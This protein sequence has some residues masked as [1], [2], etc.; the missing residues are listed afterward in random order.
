[1]PRNDLGRALIG[2][3]RND[4]NVIV[5]QLQATF[6]RF[7]NRMADVRK[8]TTP[9]NFAD[10]QREVRWHYQWAVLND[11]LPT[12]I[13][14]Q[15]LHS[16]LPHLASGKSILDDPPRL[17]FFT[18]RKEP[19]IPVEFSVAAYRFGHSMV[20]P[21]Y[22]LNE[23]TPPSSGPPD[24]RLPIFALPPKPSLLGFRRFPDTWAIDWGLFFKMR[25][26]QSGSQRLQPA[27]KIDSSLVNPLGNLPQPVVPA[28]R[29]P[30]LAERN[31]LRGL[32]MQLPSGQ[33]VAT[34]LG[35]PV[36]PDEELKVGKANEDGFKTNPTLA[37][38]SPEFKG[39]APLWYYVLA[40]SQKVF[41]NNST[42]IRLGPVGGRIVGEVFVGLLMGDSHSFLNQC[43]GWKP[44]VDFQ[45]A[46]KFGI[47]ELIA[48]ALEA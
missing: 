35:V 28:D 31:L 36:I 32:R 9:D 5:S 45:Q 27:Y 34:A 46:G 33:A 1:L 18:P 17:R 48:Q 22:R 44:R 30:S 4:E 39:N 3:P 42:P 41:E 29:F 24:A 37:S 19:F 6:L 12:I 11:F 8:A 15:L 47:A 26:N 38:I 2:D 7:H 13:G 10:V 40:D 25:D 16:I 20:R 23:V 14:E 21:Q 43:P